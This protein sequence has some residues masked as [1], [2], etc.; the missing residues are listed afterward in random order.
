MLSVAP[1]SDTRADRASSAAGEGAYRPSRVLE[2][3]E[4]ATDCGGKCQCVNTLK[5]Y[6]SSVTCMPAD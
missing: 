2:T 5:G 1:L 6:A 4:N 3:Q